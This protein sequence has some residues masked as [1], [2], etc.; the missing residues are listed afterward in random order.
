VVIWSIDC[1]PCRDD[2]ALLRR[3]TAAHPD[4]HVVLIWADDVRN[5]AAVAAVLADYG[6]ADVERWLLRD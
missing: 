1:A 3:F 5:A 4:A 6:L 2:L